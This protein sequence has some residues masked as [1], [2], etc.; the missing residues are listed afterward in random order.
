M[1]LL[2]PNFPISSLG[3][4]LS[5][6]LKPMYPKK[7]H[8]MIVKHNAAVFNTFIEFPKPIIIAANGPAI[9]AW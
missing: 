1:V 3:V 5:S 6:T 7:L 9:G 4:N 8:G 2:L